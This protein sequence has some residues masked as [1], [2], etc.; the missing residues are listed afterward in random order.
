MRTS[1]AMMA[2]RVIPP[3]EDEGTEV[4]GAVGDGGATVS[5]RGCLK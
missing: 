2:L 5:V 3:A 4:D 1:Y